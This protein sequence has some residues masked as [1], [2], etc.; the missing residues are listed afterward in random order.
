MLIQENETD[1]SD[2]A[3]AAEMTAEAD[4]WKNVDFTA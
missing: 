3:G 4:G 2:R 1:G